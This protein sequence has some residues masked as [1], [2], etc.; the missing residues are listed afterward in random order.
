LEI[1]IIIIIIIIIVVVVIF[2]ILELS[3]YSVTGFGVHP[4]S[5]Q[6]GT[7]SSC[8]GDKAAGSLSWPLSPPSSAEVKNVRSYTSTP[9]QIFMAWSVTP[10]FLYYGYR[11]SFCLR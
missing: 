11:R 6:M 5:H 10:S 1:H 8:P 9:P 2:S 7:D 3:T 4:A